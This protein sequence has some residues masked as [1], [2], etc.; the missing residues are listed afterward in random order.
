MLHFPPLRPEI[1]RFRLMLS[2]SGHRRKHACG[3][4]RSPLQFSFPFPQPLFEL[5]KELQGVVAENLL[6]DAAGMLFEQIASVHLFGQ[7]FSETAAREFR[8][9]VNPL[10]MIA[11]GP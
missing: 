10:G 9:A 3:T 11:V 5:G 4:A 2:G 7:Y 6:A 8:R 1:S